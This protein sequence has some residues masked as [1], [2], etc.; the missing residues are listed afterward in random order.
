MKDLKLLRGTAGVGEL[1]T[2]SKT[3]SLKIHFQKIHFVSYVKSEY[4]ELHT[5]TKFRKIFYQKLFSNI[6]LV[7]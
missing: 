3:K 4:V 2:D 5:R 1:K 6:N 7:A